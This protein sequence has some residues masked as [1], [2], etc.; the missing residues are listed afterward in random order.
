MAIAKQQLLAFI[1][2]LLFVIAWYKQGNIVLVAGV[3]FILPFV[4]NQ[5]FGCA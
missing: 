4:I 5:A 3:L 2:S 1:C